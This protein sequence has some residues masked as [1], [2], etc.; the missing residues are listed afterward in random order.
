MEVRRQGYAI[1]LQQGLR[2]MK[3]LDIDMSGEAVASLSHSSYDAAGNLLGAYGCS[4]RG[5]SVQQSSD[6]NLH[7]PRQRLRQLLLNKVSPH[8]IY[9][10]RKLASMTETDNSVELTF[11]DGGKETAAVVIAADGIYS[12]IRKSLLP[13]QLRYLGLMVI[14]GISPYDGSPD[15][16]RRQI[17]WL[18]SVTRVFTMPYDSSRTMWQMSF[19]CSEEEAVALSK[20]AAALLV[21]A[22][23]R[24]DG[25]DPALVRILSST[26]PTALSGHPAYDRDPFDPSEWR[27]SSARRRITFIGDAAHPMSPFKGQGANQALM[28]ALHLSEAL[29]A[30]ELVLPTRRKVWDALEE[31]ERAMALRSAEKV[32][33]SRVAAE[34]LHGPEAL[35]F[36]NITRASAASL[37]LD[38][39]S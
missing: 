26:F 4:L 10:G 3:A 20:D 31:F 8:S 36:G 32:I 25:W 12:S 14:L 11:E 29:T 19:P 13:G 7:I 16:P 2:V 1:T 24:C 27:R 35:R 5:L 18:D 30:S 39:K 37:A 22:C 15:I 23:R 28:D 6:H 21:A 38:G 17:Q 9:W 34:V 33:K